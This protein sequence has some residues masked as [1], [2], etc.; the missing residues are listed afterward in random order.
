MGH[1]HPGRPGH[2]APAP[3][4]A[5]RWSPPAHGPGAE[6]VSAHADAVAGLRDDVTGFADV[7]APHPLVRRLA[8]RSRGPAAA[9]DRPGLPTTGAARSSGRRSPGTR[10]TRRTR[11]WCATS[12]SRHR[13]RRALLLPPDP[14]ALAA[15]PYWE[16]HPFGVEQ[17][18]ADTLAAGG[19][20]P[21]RLERCAGLG[22]ARPRRL[23]THPGHRRVDRGR[24]GAGRL[25][26]RRRGQRRRLPHQEHGV[27]G[28]GR[29]AARGTDERMLEL[30]EPFAGPSRPG[31]RLLAK[32]AGM[33]RPGSARGMPIRSF[34]RY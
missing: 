13:G 21:P 8:R 32:P 22:R 1:P 25:R 12:A 4:A 11:R 6:W 15:T 14:A 23:T 9:R 27:L 18:R 16:F 31:L 29:R 7:A 34:A 17:K 24:G 10:R 26:R 2:P 19:R 28:A 20:R 30:L 3:R 5:D 33:G